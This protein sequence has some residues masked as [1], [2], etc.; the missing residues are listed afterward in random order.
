M[1]DIGNAKVEAGVNF[2]PTFFLGDLGGKVGKGT[3]FIKDL[4][5]EL[6]KL[7]KGAF[8][9][10][11]PN[12]WLGFRVAGQYTFVQGI[13]SIIE[14]SASPVVNAGGQTVGGIVLLRVLADRRA[15]E[16]ERSQL[17]TAL[18]ASTQISTDLRMLFRICSWCRRIHTSNGAWKTLEELLNVTGDVPL[19]H[20]ICPVCVRKVSTS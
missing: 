5:Y 18:R 15:G 12:E 13:D 1:F 3:T 6:T 7:M 17:I 20:G 10:I 2:G 19:S 11:Y 9:T 4:N 16:D 8:I 14:E